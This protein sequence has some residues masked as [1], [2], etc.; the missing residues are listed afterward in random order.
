M[1]M[2]EREIALDMQVAGIG[3]FATADPATRNIYAGELPESVVEGIYVLSS[4]SPPPHQYIDTEYLVV[5]FWA[6][7]PHTDRAYDLL[8]RVFELYHRRYDFMTAHWHIQ[9]SQAL[10]RIQD[11]NRDLEG[12]KLFRLSIQFICRNLNHVS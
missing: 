6:R 10:G 2:F 5:D 12:G 3:V 8:E 7:S 4:P 11:T 9:F 1:T